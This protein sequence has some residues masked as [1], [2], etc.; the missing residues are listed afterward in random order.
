MR[1]GRYEVIGTLGSGGMSAVSL[2]KSTSTGE[3]V[4]LKRQHDPADDAALI[5]E[6][7]VG[8]RLNHPHIVETLD[9][10]THEGRPTLVTAYV[11]GASL[12]DLRATQRVPTEIVLKV[13]RDIASALAFIHTATEEDGTPLEILHRDV[14]PPNV[15]IGHD[16]RAR[17]IDLG[18]ARSRVNTRE[19]TQVG[20]LR[21]TLRY[22][23]PEVLQGEP[24]TP[25][26][27]LWGLGATLWEAALGRYAVPGTD[28]QVYAQILKGE[29]FGLTPDDRV[30]ARV[31]N[32]VGALLMYDPRSRPRDAETAARI[33]ES[34]LD[35]EVD[36]DRLAALLVQRNLG[37][38]SGYEEDGGVEK[39][40]MLVN[41]AAAAYG[42]P[43]GDWRVS[44]E[45]MD[46]LTHAKPAAPPPPVVDE[47]EGASL[48]RPHLS[49]S[50]LEEAAEFEGFTDVETE[51][52]D[53]ADPRFAK[54]KVDEDDDKPTQPLT[55]RPPT[56]AVPAPL[57][58]PPPPSPSSPGRMIA[59]PVS[60]EAPLAPPEGVL[61]VHTP[62]PFD[63][64]PSQEGAAH[65]V[66]A[67]VL[68][69]EHLPILEIP[70]DQ[71]KT[72]VIDVD[73][74]ALRAALK[75]DALPLLEVNP[76]RKKKKRD[77]P[78][79]PDDWLMPPTEAEDDDEET[80]ATDPE[81]RTSTLTS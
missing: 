52:L 29:V 14:T 53:K 79:R 11:S 8:L 80:S 40:F 12:S 44:S 71:Q 73:R 24:Y 27:D 61:D 32:A 64:P 46:K 34:Y 74:R 16:G 56:G 45:V 81:K 18:I 68:S 1:I 26:T 17:L 21:G 76:T 33:F 66:N 31:R 39:T 30:D 58:L 54:P 2:A 36:A 7:R 70:V 5:D 67:P 10:F 38:A 49:R 62:S 78:Y 69:I 59:A 43:L 65:D 42:G 20:F 25:Q 55:P 6:A 28:P 50:E 75:D 41:R 72:Q 13:G 4:V 57:E 48:T 22:I 15:L 77:R 35:P 23:A 19:H 60:M 9:L 3:L 63:G 51:V 47:R 37:P